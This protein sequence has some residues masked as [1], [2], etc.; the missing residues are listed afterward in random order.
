MFFWRLFLALYK[1][2]Y[3]L[4]PAGSRG[5]SEGEGAAHSGGAA[6]DG[7]GQGGVCRGHRPQEPGHRPA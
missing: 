4:V 6:A 7:G 2:L 1:S 5:S 3:P